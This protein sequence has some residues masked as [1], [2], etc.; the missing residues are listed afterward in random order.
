MME[1]LPD[2]NLS[3]FTKNR[4]KCISLL[5]K[6]YLLYSVSMALRHLES[7]KIVH[8]DIK[9]NNVMLAPG[10]QVKI[11]DFGEAFHPNVWK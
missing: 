8:L 7:Y 9:P 6:L 3:E 4:K 1:F 11:I 5:T 10:L 2:G